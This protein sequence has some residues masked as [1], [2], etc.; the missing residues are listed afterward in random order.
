MNADMTNAPQGD[1]T[2]A[3]R[4]PVGSVSLDGELHVPT[5]AQGIVLFAHAAGRPSPRWRALAPLLHKAGLGTLR[6]DLITPEETRADADRRHLRFNIGLL[7]QRLT[8]LSHRR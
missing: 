1:P 3:V 4:I 6:F 7:T 5:A 8:L 2:L